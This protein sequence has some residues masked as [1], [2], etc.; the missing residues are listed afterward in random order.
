M[1]ATASRTRASVSLVSCPGVLSARETVIGETPAMRATSA[2]VR[3][4][5][6]RRPRRTR[7]FS[8]GSADDVLVDLKRTLDDAALFVGLVGIAGEQVALLVVVGYELPLALERSINHR[9]PL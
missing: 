7:L 9:A 8:R 2:R 4:P 3:A 5:P 1:R 6:R